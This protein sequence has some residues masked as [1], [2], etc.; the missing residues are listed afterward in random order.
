MVEKCIAAERKKCA[1]DSDDEVEDDEDDEE[2][3]DEDDEEEEDEEEEKEEIIQPRKR[4]KKGSGKKELDLGSQ[5]LPL[6]TQDD[7]PSS[8]ASGNL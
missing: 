6:L 8:I 1:L 3:D 2:E 5:L 7:K 4:D